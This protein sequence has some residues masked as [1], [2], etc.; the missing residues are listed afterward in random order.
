[1][2]VKTRTKIE[3][4]SELQNDISNSN[5]P[6]IAIKNFLNSKKIYFYITPIDNDT[7]QLDFDFD[8]SAIAHIELVL[9]LLQVFLNTT[10]DRALNQLSVRKN[11]DSDNIDIYIP[12]YNE[13][14]LHDC[15]IPLLKINKFLISI[16]KQII[17]VR[18]ISNES[19]LF[20]I[21]GD[22]IEKKRVSILL[23]KFLISDKDYSYNQLYIK[24]N[25]NDIEICIPKNQDAVALKILKLEIDINTCERE[26]TINKNK[27]IKEKKTMKEKIRKLSLLKNKPIKPSNFKIKSI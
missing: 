5:V 27:L 11:N 24:N 14:D 15:K 18:A 22:N 16:K 1:M 19:V 3:T 8:N 10:Q 25:N 7:I 9:N 20:L 21:D 26:Y 2:V 17:E 6:L 12:Q 4:E 23:Q 13:F